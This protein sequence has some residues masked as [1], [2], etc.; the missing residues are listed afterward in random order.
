[1]EPRE[2]SVTDDKVEYSQEEIRDL[3]AMIDAGNRTRAGP[4]SAG[5]GV[6]K[7]VSAF[8]IVGESCLAG[9]LCSAY[10]MNVCHVMFVFFSVTNSYINVQK[11]PE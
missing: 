6:T 1:M 7:V 5:G 3:V 8:G 4:R 10:N 2:L 9:S 11:S